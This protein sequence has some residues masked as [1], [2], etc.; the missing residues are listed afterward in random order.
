M[1]FIPDKFYVGVRSNNLGFMTTMVKEGYAKRKQTVDS[2]CSS[3]YR[4]NP[5][6]SRTFEVDNLFKKGFK[7]LVNDRRYRTDNVVWNIEHPEGFTFQISSENF[8]DILRDDTIT[9]GVLKGEYRFVRDGSNNILVKKGNPSFAKVKTQKE[10]ETKVSTTKLEIG[11]K[12]TLKSTGD[13]PYIYLGAFHFMPDLGRHTRWNEKPEYD[14]EQKTVKRHVFRKFGVD[15]FDNYF[16]ITLASPKVLGIVEKGAEK[17]T[18]DDSYEELKASLLD[19]ERKER[20]GAHNFWITARPVRLTDSSIIGISKKATTLDNMKVS[21]V[22]MPK[23]SDIAFV[24]SNMTLL[25]TSGNNLYET[26]DHGLKLYCDSGNFSVYETEALDLKSG[27]KFYVPTY[28]RSSGWQR[29]WSK[30]T[31]F[32]SRQR[33]HA[34]YLGQREVFEFDEPQFFQLLLGE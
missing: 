18:F 33:H 25:D 31:I 17:L 14:K 4:A 10:I 19:Y 24:Y 5:S 7:V 22:E 28:Y 21:L 8:C 26:Q 30:K 3:G 29:G 16:Y 2:W 11:D 15:K 12:V 6:G 13:S 34:G 32:Q 27:D 20:E 1:R 9:K 23:G